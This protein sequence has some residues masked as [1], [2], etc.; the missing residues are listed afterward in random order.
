MGLSDAL[1]QELAQLSVAEWQTV[2]LK[3]AD[4]FPGGVKAAF[5]VATKTY[6]GAMP[7]QV[8]DGPVL[9]RA[10]EFL[11][12]IGE[13]PPML[14][15]RI[16]PDKSLVLLAGKP[17]AGKSLA[18]I[19]M[20]DSVCQGKDVWGCFPTNRKGPVVY[21]GMEDGKYEIANRL[22]ARGMKPGDERQL[23]VCYRRLNL[24]L[25]ESMVHLRQMM[26]GIDPVLV[27]IDTA[28]EALGIA[29]WSNAG[30]VVDKVRPLRD[31]ARDVCSVLLVA[32][33]RKAVAEDSGDEIAGT[34][35]FTGAVDGWISAFKTQK[36]KELHRLHL[37]ADGRG[38]M[39]DEFILDM[40]LKTLRFRTL[41]E[42]ESE[43]ERRTAE[44]ETRKE[45]FIEFAHAVESLGNEA[46]AVQIS[47][48]TGTEYRNSK[49]IVGE[50]IQRRYL[51]DS[52]KRLNTGTA[53]RPAVLYT[54]GPR[55]SELLNNVSSSNGYA[56][57]KLINPPSQDADELVGSFFKTLAPT[58][59]S[60]GTEAEL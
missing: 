4:N 45:K 46:T 44:E 41:T 38:G 58:G 12:S 57:E 18:A 43:Q 36:S 3:A 5:D 34:N 47:D 59:P 32:H 29:D 40:N 14:V 52:G 21:L 54:L 28:R 24:S 26:V 13:P 55:I 35:A 37:K 33:N 51:V 16:L 2:L 56:P 23:H 1:V 53:G 50:M 25:P 11:L 9:M 48:A 6:A 8:E 10:G 49:I 31:F 19:D 60:N 39:R 7:S 20:A 22:L 15:D 17:K 42:E 30:E 27:V